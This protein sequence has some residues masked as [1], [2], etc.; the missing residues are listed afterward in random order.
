M[1]I[2]NSSTKFY[3]MK[4]VLF[5]FGILMS[6]S[7]Q[8]QK[9][10]EYMITNRFKLAGDGG[11]DYIT[12]QESTGKLFVSHGTE[13]QVLDVTHGKMIAE[14]TGLKGVHG[15]A[16]VQ[17][18]NRGYIT[19][20]KD[21]SVTV[22]DLSTYEKV[23]MIKVTGANPD[24]LLY[25]PFSGKIFV[26]NGRSSNATV[27]DASTNQVIATIALAG[28]P[29]FSVSD[30]DGKVFVNIED[31]SEVC[32]INSSTLKVE[33]YW[34]IKP[35]AGPSGL[36][37]DNESHRLFSVCDKMM[38]ILDAVTGKVITT[39]PIGD[40]VDGVAFDP[41][42]KRIYSSNGDGT[43]TVVQEF[44]E[45]HFEVIDN[46]LTQV[47]ARTITLNKNTH[48]IYMPA[49]EYGETPAKTDENPHPRPLIKPN[50]FVILE[51]SLIK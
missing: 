42:L 29:E 23:A 10:T 5:V 28:K 14:I 19:N 9:A 34:T 47:G 27:I 11:W 1:K 49:A 48:T 45:N 8:S 51:V 44:D 37:L 15:I 40:R 36:A 39:L 6:L 50:S 46:L 41:A 2:L 38:V 33:Q 31:K 24:A 16:L 4:T 32:V 13:I 12:M 7:V 20:G 25:D 35:G 21:S 26:F 30:G 3:P 22:I 17:D 43:M 18:L